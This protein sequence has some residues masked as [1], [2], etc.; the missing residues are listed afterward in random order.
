[1]GVVIVCYVS[2]RGGWRV[3]SERGSPSDGCSEAVLVLIAMFKRCVRGD[4]AIS[5]RDSM[6]KGER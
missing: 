1:M 4:A 3:G 6:Q 2:Q 5:A